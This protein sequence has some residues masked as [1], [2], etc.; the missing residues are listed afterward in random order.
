MSFNWKQQKRPLICLAPMADYTDSPFS[1]ICK[2]FGADVIYREMVSAEALVRGNEKTL[3]MAEFDKKERP[4]I[5]QIFGQNPETMAR[6]A[7]VLEEKFH[8]DGIDINMGCPARKIISNFNGAS[9]MKDPKLAV[10]IVEAVKNAV[11]V[12]VS[13]KTRTGWSDEKEILKFAPILEAAGADA[14]AIHGRT[15]TMGYTGKANWEIIARAKEKLSIPV[16]L[17]GDI[18]DFESFSRAIAVSGADGVLIG[19]GAL[20]FPWIFQNIKNKKDVVPT[21]TE[22]KKIV[23][24]H[25]KAHLARYGE[26]VSFRKHLLSYFKSTAGAKKIRVKLAQVKS[27]EDLMEALK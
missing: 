8:P 10:K 16:L 1:L 21:L 15:K 13:V 5:L 11:A 14:I 19:R 22:I 2:K 17:N 23:L 25:A 20:G 18:H 6:A 27:L 26:L 9:L 7:A 3:K 12:P 24:S 4:I